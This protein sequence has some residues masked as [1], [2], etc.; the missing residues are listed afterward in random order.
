MTD[1]LRIDWTL[2]LIAAALALFGSAMVYSASAMI[3]LK[4]TQSATQ[5]SYFYKQFAFSL[6]GL[7]VMYAGSRIDYRRYATPRFVFGLMAI[8]VASLFIVFLFPAINGASRWI[9]AGGV[10]FQPSELAKI[11]LPIFLAYYLS[12][13][14]ADA[15]DFRWGVLP[16]IVGLAA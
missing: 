7:A 13:D 5:F 11:A 9:R 10:S 8:T 16:C 15:G 4:E 2:F 14:E 6:L 12:R 3:S 1:R